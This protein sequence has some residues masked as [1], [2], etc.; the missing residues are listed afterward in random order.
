MQVRCRQKVLALDMDGMS[1]PELVVINSYLL[2]T[3]RRRKI[4]GA[5]IRPPRLLPATKLIHHGCQVS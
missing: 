1:M 3:M 5:G 2:A 4:A